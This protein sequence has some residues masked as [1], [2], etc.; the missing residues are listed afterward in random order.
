M[1]NTKQITLSDT[2]G[3]SKEWIESKKRTCESNIKNSSTHIVQYS[4]YMLEFITHLEQQLFPI[5]P[6]VS[7]AFEK[8]ITAGYFGEY[9]D[10]YL[11]QPIIIKLE[12]NG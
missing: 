8:G 12:D 1:S 2:Y 10:D 7:E 4:Q 5:E 3:I 9:K 11:T 6:I